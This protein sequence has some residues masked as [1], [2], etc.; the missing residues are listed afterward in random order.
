MGW[1]SIVEPNDGVFKQI[2][3]TLHQ[4]DP[5]ILTMRSLSL[6]QL[7]QWLE[8]YEKAVPEAT[9]LLPAGPFKGLIVAVDEWTAKDID[10]FE[11]IPGL[12]VRL[13][14]S[15]K[16]E[17][18]F[19][20]LTGYKTSEIAKKRFQKPEVNNF[21]AKPFDNLMLK[22]MLEI[23]ITGRK[24]I[25]KY[26]IHNFKIDLTIEM[27][28]EIR[29]KEVTEIG[30]QTESDQKIELGRIAKYYADFLETNQ[31]RSAFARPTSV[32]EIPG[33]PVCRVNLTF[34]ALDNQQSLNLQK[35]IQAKKRKR[36]LPV[37]PGHR[38]KYEFL[39]VD[40]E[41]NKLGAEVRPSIER[42]FDH[43]IDTI[44]S[45]TEID[46][47]FKKH[48]AAHRPHMILFLDTAQAAGDE[49][50]T[51]QSIHQANS[52][53]AIFLLSS[54]IFPEAKE[55]E[56]SQFCEDIFYAPF[57]RS[58][59]I[60]TLK[61]KWPD[62]RAK[63]EIFENHDEMERVIHVSNP[64]KIVEVSEAGLVME[65]YRPLPVGSFRQFILWM[66][67]EINVPVILGQCNFVESK[68]GGKTSLCH[69]VF[70][71]AE[72]VHTKHIRRWMLHNYIE[73]KTAE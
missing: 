33:S 27:L 44:R 22:Q 57:N 1:V 64:V 13:L 61:R 51:C 63:D 5:T 3:E 56:L 32:V 12:L 11:K 37:T 48:D 69:F 39:F 10:Q 9:A 42:F 15:P 43:Q 50:G 47:V 36:P 35:M 18:F 53:V 17:D 68:P 45:L 6:A 71:A 55:F 8:Q 14:I 54:K 52:N 23:A 66:P 24:K 26:H 25:A 67:D 70:F 73:K 40:D 31:H 16:P 46:G 59:I 34:F 49:V 21:L 7:S 4:I 58:H 19:V 41:K 60:K 38:V 72:D 29:L 30:F 20:V 28:K 62:L 65:Y 2:D